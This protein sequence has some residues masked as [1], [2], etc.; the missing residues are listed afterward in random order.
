MAIAKRLG[1]K[2]VSFSI[3]VDYGATASKKEI[4]ANL[5]GARRKDITI[6]HFNQ[7]Q[8]RTA[9]G[10]RK[11]LPKMIHAGRHFGTLSKVMG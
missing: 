2:V 9:E 5:K 4:V 1:L 10:L 11:E 8:G 6:A 3:N 7:P